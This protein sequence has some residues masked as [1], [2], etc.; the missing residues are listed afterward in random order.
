MSDKG[1]FL[2]IVISIIVVIVLAL[3]VVVLYNAFQSRI[4]KE[5][6]EAHEKEIKYKNSIIE[7][8]IEV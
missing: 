2:I 8:T 4:L 1:L 3:G 7:N 6:E 5:L